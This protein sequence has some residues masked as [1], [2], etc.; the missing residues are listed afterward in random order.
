MA[1]GI[2]IGT[3]NFTSH[4]LPSG[5]TQV[6][7]IQSSGTQYINTGVQIDSDGKIDMD[8]EIPTE[9]T[10]QLFVFGVSVTGDNERYGVTYLP[11]NK[12]WRNV[13]STG[14][15]SEANFPT[16]LKAVGRHRIVKDGNQCTIDG[17]TMSTTQRTFTSS[18]YVFLFARN[19]EGNPIHLASA[20]LYSCKMYRKGALAR[21]FV[22]CKN[23][24]GTVGLYD[25]VGK[26]FY[27]NAGTGVFI[28]GENHK[29]NIASKVHTIYVGI[30][31]DV[32]IIEKAE[33]EVPFSAAN[34]DKFF[35]IANGDGTSGWSYAD[36]LSENN[37]RLGVRFT[38]NNFGV[39]SSTATITLTLKKDL[40]GGKYRY[41]HVS[42]VNYDKFTLKIGSETIL[43]GASGA[44]ASSVDNLNT[45]SQKAGQKIV[46]TYAKD[47][48]NSESAETGEFLLVWI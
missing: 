41:L 24:S 25:L 21:D 38:P 23:A 19:Q 2:Y 48:S 26:Q 28:A 39:N 5:Y 29:A 31:T 15:G 27:A 3:E 33:V 43:N 42:E 7:Y 8:V 13:H 1:R 18:R 4:S 36:G 10:A 35:D 44:A 40:T 32:P 11:G 14:D 37:G 16:A 45:A 47:S 17:I 30:S 12:Y 22:P 46:I 20:R 6:E 9:P 34:I